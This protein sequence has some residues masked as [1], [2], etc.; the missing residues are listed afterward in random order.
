HR[1]ALNNY[2]DALISATRKARSHAIKVVFD[3]SL[4]PASIVPNS[5]AGVRT[6]LPLS[7]STGALKALPLP[8]STGTLKALPM[9]V[10]AIPHDNAKDELRQLRHSLGLSS[11][12]SNLQSPPS[13]ENQ[14]EIKEAQTL[15]AFAIPE[16]HPSSAIEIVV[17]PA[18]QNEASLPA[19]ETLPEIT[20]PSQ[21]IVDTTKVQEPIVQD[22]LDTIAKPATASAQEEQTSLITEIGPILTVPDEY[23]APEAE[24]APKPT[25]LIPEKLIPIIEEDPQS[26]IET[27]QITPVEKRQSNGN[28]SANPVHAEGTNEAKADANNGFS[29]SGVEDTPTVR[30]RSKRGSRKRRTKPFV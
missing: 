15:Q 9:P 27:A 25:E 26:A 10:R 28:G 22:K 19:I 4:Q 1:F 24:T 30:V 12:T 21:T 18:D 2:K 14:P 23:P 8:T 7:T 6:P 3:Y 5:K 17:V 16:E 29:F 20:D 11:T 13:E